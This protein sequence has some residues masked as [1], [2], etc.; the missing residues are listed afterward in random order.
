MQNYPAGGVYILKIKLEEEKEI[1]IGALGLQ[2]FRPGYYFYAGTAQK[3]F[4][5]RIKRHY[6][7]SKNFHWHI[8][9]F[10]DQANLKKDFSF[11]LPAVGECFLAHVLIK[12]GGLTPIEGFGASDCKCGSHLIYF[13]FA[14]GKKVIEN[15]MKNR[16]LSR[17][18]K[19]L[20]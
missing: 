20:N 3:N 11:K 9:Y 7:Q 12:A 2:T 6:S 19:A 8:D 5:A 4:E 18:F 14:Q 13:S 1:K 15:L 16:N 10:L 17:E